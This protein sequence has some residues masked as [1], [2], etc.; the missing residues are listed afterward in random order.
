MIDRT[1]WVLTVDYDSVFE[2]EAVSRLLTAA[3]VSGYDAIAPLQ[4]KRDDGVPMFT[5]EG[6]GHKIG[7]VQLP[8]SWFEAVVQPVDS[9]HFG[10]DADSF[11]GTQAN[12][13]PVVSWHAQGLTGTGATPPKAKTTV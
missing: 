2:P 6:H 5:P 1:D 8:T 10:L 7:M 13:D 11:R 4:V 12:A 9:A 3:L